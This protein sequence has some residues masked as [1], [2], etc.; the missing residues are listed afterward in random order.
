MFAS[1][2]LYLDR[3]MLW[4]LVIYNITEECQKQVMR[5]FCAFE[6]H[7]CAIDVNNRELIW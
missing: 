3:N 1:D 7:L 6:K 4:F 5:D 2:E